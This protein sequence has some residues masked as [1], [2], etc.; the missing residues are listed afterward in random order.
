MELKQSVSIKVPVRL[1]AVVDGSPL[2]GVTYSQVVVYIQKHGGSSAVKTLAPADWVEI[3]ATNM[4]GEYDMLLAT[5]E[6]DTLG[7]FKYIVV[8]PGISTYYAGLM[9]VVA[10]I[11]SDTY[12]RIG[13]PASA[14]IAGDIAGVRGASNRDLTQVDTNV[15]AL[16]AGI[17][18]LLGLLHKNAVVMDQTYNP[19][20]R[21][22]AATLKVYDTAAH[23]SL[24]DGVTGLLKTYSI[25]ATYDLLQ[26]ESLYRLV[27]VP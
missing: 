1:R 24:N 2:S 22:T 21:L 10:N 16:Q 12:T 8:Y 3:D 9:Q 11:E 27:E 4:P 18:E 20:G 19:A 26:H 5:G 17:T 6:V 25:F 14:S 23:A 7:F 15:L 13:L